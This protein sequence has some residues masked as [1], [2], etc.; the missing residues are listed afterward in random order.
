MSW[1]RRPSAMRCEQDDTGYA[2]LNDAKPGRVLVVT[3]G[4]VALEVALA[5]RAGRA[6]G[7]CRVQDAGRA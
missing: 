3:P 4:N 1:I 5:T 2:A 7:E 6:A